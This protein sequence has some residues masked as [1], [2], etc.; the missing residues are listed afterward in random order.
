MYYFHLQLDQLMSQYKLELNER[1]GCSAPQQVLLFSQRWSPSLKDFSLENQVCPVVIVA[2]KMES[3]Y[4]GRVKQ[5]PLLCHT[6]QRY[7]HVL[8]LLGSNKK[9]VLIVTSDT[10]EAKRLYEVLKA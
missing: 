3:A 9:K 5:K 10:A 6:H 2:A 7:N 8:S 4:Y 1:H